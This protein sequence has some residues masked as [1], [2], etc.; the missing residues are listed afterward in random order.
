MGPDGVHLKNCRR[1][2]NLKQLTEKP[3][4]RHAQVAIAGAL[5]IFSKNAS[6]RESYKTHAVVLLVRPCPTAPLKF[7]LVDAQ[8]QPHSKAIAHLRS[9]MAGQEIF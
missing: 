1:I 6:L 8:V 3:A 4:F 5:H 7:T 2:D 9:S